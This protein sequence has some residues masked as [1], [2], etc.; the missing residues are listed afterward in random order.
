MT[1]DRR[2][3]VA[4]AALAVVAPITDLPARPSAPLAAGTRRVVVLIDGWSVASD[5]ETADRV[6]I[7]IDRGWRTSWR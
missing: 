4:G 7:R 5:D 2:T 1:I 3:F 6:W